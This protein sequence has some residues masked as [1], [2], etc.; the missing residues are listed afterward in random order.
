MTLAV[1]IVNL[2]L[3]LLVTWRAFVTRRLVV[4]PWALVTYFAVFV[5]P[6]AYSGAY[7]RFR[8][9]S[10]DFVSVSETTVSAVVVFM[11]LFNAIAFVSDAMVWRGLGGAKVKIEWELEKNNFRTDISKFILLMFLMIGGGLFWQKMRLLGYREYVEFSSQGANWPIVFL[12]AS[13]PLITILALQRRYVLASVCC[14]PFLF[15]AQHLSVRSFALLSLVPASAVFYMQR[16]DNLAKRKGEFLKLL[17][18]A[19][20][21]FLLLVAVSTVVMEKKTGRVTGL[22]DTGIVYGVGLVFAAHKHGEGDQGFISLRK[23]SQNVVSPLIKLAGKLVGYREPVLEDTP[24]YIA[25]LI[26]GVPKHSGVYFHYP[27]LWYSDAFVSFGAGGL[28]LAALWGTVLA[29]IERLTVSRPLLIALILPFYVW[30][31]YMLVRGATAIATVPVSYA[32]YFSLM[33][34]AI[35][36]PVGAK[37]IRRRLEKVPAGRVLA[38]EQKQRHATR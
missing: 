18:W 10:G 29:A 12:W 21:V 1:S 11:V 20:P 32:F 25:R 31:A 7:R 26:D 34:L 30:H 3:C 13:S 35:A 8:G 24:V 9:F 23:Y 4:L 14:L 16:A 2:L 33:A 5:V 6:M 17:L 15:F 28:L 22:P 36:I 37:P 19:V 27:A 38:S